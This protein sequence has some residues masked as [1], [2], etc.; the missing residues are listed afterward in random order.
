M[1]SRELPCL[2]GHLLALF[3][4]SHGDLQDRFLD[5]IICDEALAPADSHERRLIHQVL[6]IGSC[7]A[8]RSLRDGI[9]VDIV[10]E[11][12]PAGVDLQDRLTTADVRKSHVNLPVEAAGTQQRIVENIRAVRRRHN[13]DAVVVPET[14]HL[15]EELVQ[16]L[17]ALVMTAAEAAASLPSD[18]IDLVDEDDRRRDLLCLFKQITDTS[19]ADADIELNKIGAGDREKLNACLPGNGF[20]EERFTGARRADEQHAL[21]DARTHF[22]ILL[23]ILEEMDD[24][25]QF[26]LFLVA[27]GHIVKRGLFLFVT[28]ELR[29]GF[30]EP[31]NAAG[32]AL[33]PIH[34]DRPDDDENDHYDQI[35]QERCPPRRLP[36]GRIIILLQDPLVF[37]LLHQIVQIIVKD[38]DR[39][40]LA[41]HDALVLQNERQLIAFRDKGLHLFLQE[42]ITNLGILRIRAFLAVEV[43]REDR[44]KQDHDQQGI[45]ADVPCFVF[46]RFIVQMK[47]TS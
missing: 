3:L 31:G 44:G 4:G 23:G 32:A 46:S 19:R 8:G 29:A 7:K 25:S 21:G 9:E 45:K 24:F 17:L 35:G 16:R 42:K 5:L 41:G 12:F 28:A 36:L 14:V 6:Q 27:A 1:V 37:L 33:H 39:A 10:S 2:V 18:R 38:A 30:T 13:D 20:C 40:Q 34:R 26:F 43:H 47:L 11:R 15:H 22:R